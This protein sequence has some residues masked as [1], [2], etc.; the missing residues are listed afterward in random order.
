MRMLNWVFLLEE[1]DE[2]VEWV[3]LLEEPCAIE[4]SLAGQQQLMLIR[5]VFG[6]KSLLRRCNGYRVEQIGRFRWKIRV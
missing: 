4:H 6:Y 3:F 5:F 2:E 1:T